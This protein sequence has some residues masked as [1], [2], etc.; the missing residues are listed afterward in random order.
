MRR[1]VGR[2]GHRACTCSPFWDHGSAHSSL[3]CT[4]AHSSFLLSPDTRRPRPGQASP[5]GA[6]GLDLKQE[7][8]VGRGGRREQ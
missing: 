8:V 6:L 5:W 4:T 3:G 7:K 2:E 1:P